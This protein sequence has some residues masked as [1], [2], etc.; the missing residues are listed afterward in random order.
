LLALRCVSLAPDAPRR[1]SV[2]L[3]A[4]LGGGAGGA[5]ARHALREYAAALAAAAAPAAPASDAAADAPAPAAP[6]AADTPPPPP[7]LLLFLEKVGVPAGAAARWLAL[8]PG[9]CLRTQLA[10][11]WLVEHPTIHV[12]LPRQREDY[13]LAEGAAPEPPPAG[14]RWI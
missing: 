13:P 2:G 9:A 5:A 7:P 11:K 4:Q 10:G 8:E 14:N 3:A 12:A 1:R 6:P